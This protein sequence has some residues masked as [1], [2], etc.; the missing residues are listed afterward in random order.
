MELSFRAITIAYYLTC[1]VDDTSEELAVWILE[2]YDNAMTVCCCE[3][4]ILI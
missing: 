4:I 2:E 3:F 1:N